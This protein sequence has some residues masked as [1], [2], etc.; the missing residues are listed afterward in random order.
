MV[1]RYTESG[2]LYDDGQPDFSWVDQAPSARITVTK[3]QPEWVESTPDVLRDP[4]NNAFDIAAER[5]RKSVQGRKSEVVDDRYSAFG[6]ANPEHPSYIMEP[7]LEEAQGGMHL[8]VGLMQTD[9]GK[10]Y[11][12]DNP[13]TEIPM[14]RR[15]GIIPIANTPEGY[16]FVVPKMLDIVGNVVSPLAAGKVPVKAGEMVLGSGMVRKAEE[17]SPLAIKAKEHFGITYNPKE[18]G[19]IM[20]DGTMLDLSGRHQTRE[21]IRD[22]SNRNVLAPGQNRDYMRDARNVDH[23]EVGDLLDNPASAFEAMQTFMNDAK[24]IR[25]MPGVGFDTTFVPTDKQLQKIISGHNSAYRGEPLKVDISNPVNGD[26]IASKSFDKPNIEVV[27]KWINE[28]TGKHPQLFSDTRPQIANAVGKQLER[29]NAQGFYSGL[30]RAVNNAKVEKAGAEQ[31]LGY[32][33]NQPGVKQEELDTVLRDLPKGMIT[34]GQLQELVNSNKVQ[35]QEKVLGGYNSVPDKKRMVEIR[36]RL[37]DIQDQYD[38]YSGGNSKVIIDTRKK[39]TE[40]KNKLLNEYQDLSQKIDKVETKYHSYQLPGGENYREMLVSLPSKEK[41]KNWKIRDNPEVEGEFEVLNDKGRVVFGTT[42]REDAL[43]YIKDQNIIDAKNDAFNAPHFD[44]AGKNLLYHV[45]MNDRVIDGKKTLHIEEIQSDWLQQGR[46]YGFKGE[47]AKLEPEFNK[48]EQKIIDSGDEAIM[49]DPDLK[50]ALAKAVDKKIITKEE[51]SQYERYTKVEA[52][53][54]AGKSVPNAPFKKSWE[55]LALKRMIRKAA[56]EG[57]D[58]ISWTSGEAQALR[59][60]NEIRQKINKIEWEP[61]ASYMKKFHAD[62][63]LKDITHIAVEGADG[64]KP[65]FNVDKNGIVTAASHNGA[66]GKTIDE[67]LGKD[68]AKQIMEKRE[69]NIDAKGYVM[70]AEGFKQAYDKRAV[71]IANNIAKK[72]G[73]KVESKNLNKSTTNIEMKKQYTTAKGDDS[74]GIY[75]DGKLIKGDMFKDEAEKYLKGY[76]ESAANRNPVNVHY[77]PLSPQLKRKA[78]EEGFPLFSSTPTT[79]PVDYTP[80]FDDKAKNKK[81]RLVPVKG[82]PF[83]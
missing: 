30:E 53:E 45:R 63:D 72:Y 12:Y 75:E 71:D 11:Y 73:A 29:P 33:R 6:P 47:K 39:L 32:L 3:R 58:A 46:D 41:T 36:Q 2:E 62:A 27:K 16:K 14:V 1:L 49:G 74:Y 28:E 51:A 50:S 52:G 60:Q 69:G 81:Y 76:K 7:S 5:T 80:E 77:L 26:N 67:I 64:G 54:A 24:A 79:V 34:K 21:F 38:S 10:F 83:Q 68:F 18:A 59:Y 25:N 78:M 4:R 56:E 37:G 44:D 42:D 57:Y 17:L 55:E 19:Y 22:A 65:W 31:W 23:R 9:G 70:G 40:E 15:P 8:P 48:I 43:N 61:R 20:P 82:N 13:Q 35:L 66:K